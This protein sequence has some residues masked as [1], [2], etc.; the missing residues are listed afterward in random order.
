MI[1]REFTAQIIDDFKT[2][3]IAET[4][5]NENI[6]I[7]EAIAAYGGSRLEALNDRISGQ[8]VTIVEHEYPEG[9]DDF[10]EKKDDNFVIYR[11]LFEEI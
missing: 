4:A 6:T 5:K 8:R 3:W 2:W 9:D 7:D 1:K 11:K 10:F